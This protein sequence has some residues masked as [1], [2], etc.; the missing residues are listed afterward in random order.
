ML[1][2]AKW[3]LD[4][5]LKMQLPGRLGARRACT[6][7]GFASDSPPSADTN[8]RFYHDPND[9]VGRGLRGRELRARLAGL[10]AAGHVGYAA[11]LR[12]AALATWPRVLAQAN[13]EFKVWAAA[14]IFRMDP[15][16]A[17]ARPAR[18]RATTPA[19]GP[20]SSST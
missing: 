3:E 16:V 8:L 5:L 7:P 13:N 6:S 15:T 10:P 14:E 12:A 9:A 20:A 17:A 19:T 2:E 4:W 11:R 1:D 18:R